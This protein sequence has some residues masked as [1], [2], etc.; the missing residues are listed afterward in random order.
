MQNRSKI[1]ECPLLAHQSFKHHH[2]MFRHCVFPVSR[3]LVLLHSLRL[4]INCGRVKSR[5]AFKKSLWSRNGP[6]QFQRNGAEMRWRAVREVVACIR[7]RF[8]HRGVVAVY[9][10]FLFLVCK[11]AAEC[12]I[13]MSTARHVRHVTFR[14]PLLCESA[15]LECP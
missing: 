5:C 9:L 3:L 8:Q 6:R 2:F 14:P 15:R 7:R 12:G 4:H 1:P 10:L 13:V 11:N